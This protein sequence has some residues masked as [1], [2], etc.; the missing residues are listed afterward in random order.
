M[1][2]EICFRS[3]LYALRR[4]KGK[5]PSSLCHT[6]IKFAHRFYSIKTKNPNICTFIYILDMLG[7]RFNFSLQFKT[8]TRIV[9]V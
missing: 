5:I 8:F 6:H 2:K 3:M 7:S 4:Q 9:F 1:G